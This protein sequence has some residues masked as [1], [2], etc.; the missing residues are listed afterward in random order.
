MKY[1]HGNKNLKNHGFVR[2]IYWPKQEKSGGLAGGLT[3]FMGRVK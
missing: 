3:D 2:G 1:S